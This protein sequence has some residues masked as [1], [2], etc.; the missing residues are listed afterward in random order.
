LVA[1]SVMMG[2]IV[3]ASLAA[4]LLTDYSP[5]RI[6]SAAALLPPS[7]AHLFGTNQFGQD[8]FTRTLYAGRVDLLIGILIVGIA[9]VVGTTVGLVSSWVGG[10]LDSLAMRIVDIGFAFP[11]LVLVI[12]MV[13]LLGPGLFSLVLAVSL[14]AW[15]FYARLVRT[16]VQVVKGQNYITAARVSGFSSPRILGRHVLPNVAPQLIVYA[17]SDFVYAVLLGASVSYL[18]LGVQPPHPEWGAMI[19][20]GQSF[21]GNQWW[22]SFFPGLAVVWTG[23]ACA[24]L[25]DGLAEALRRGTRRTS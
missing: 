24:L 8:I 17:T 25:G 18:G 6:N 15:I 21:I 12:T 20:A 2:L 16:E 1:G 13:G 7:S 23:V 10:W 9:L 14:V 19:Q 11:F 5:T 4:P 22:I 3:V